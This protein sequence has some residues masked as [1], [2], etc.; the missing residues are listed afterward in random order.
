MYPF[1]KEHLFSKIKRNRTKQNT[2]YI[3]MLNLET[4]RNIIMLIN[5]TLQTLLFFNVELNQKEM[6]RQT[7]NN[8]KIL[9]QFFH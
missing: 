1:P 7:K 9:N 5:L 6:V 8:E 3:Y 4:Q 2:I